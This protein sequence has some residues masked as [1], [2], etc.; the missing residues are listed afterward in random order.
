[1]S[2]G[3]FIHSPSTFINAGHSNAQLATCFLVAMLEDSIEGIY[4]TFR[5]VAQIIKTG[6]EVGVH[7]HNIRAKG[8]P[9]DGVENLSAGIMPVMKNFDAL[10]NFVTQGGKVSNFATKILQPFIQG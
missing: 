3:F 4:D 2:Q 8:C 10:V 9:V 7:L 6:G 1:M 5:N